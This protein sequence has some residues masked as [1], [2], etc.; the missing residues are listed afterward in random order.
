MGILTPTLSPLKV[1]W[2]PTG[3]DGIS[4]VVITMDVPACLSPT[5]VNYFLRALL[6]NFDNPPGLTKDAQ[7]VAAY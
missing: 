3:R 5:K 6:E 2:Y 7:D 4:Q 1:V